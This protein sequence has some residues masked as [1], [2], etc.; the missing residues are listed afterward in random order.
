[1]RKLR[2][3]SYPPPVGQFAAILEHHR[4]DDVFCFRVVFNFGERAEQLS[5][6][7]HP[8]RELEQV[9]GLC[10]RALPSTVEGGTEKKHGVATPPPWREGRVVEGAGW[11]GAPGGEGAG[12]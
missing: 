11:W 8:L 9:F 6:V 12:W 5:V 4:L 10:A 1:M 3:T 2:N 7:P